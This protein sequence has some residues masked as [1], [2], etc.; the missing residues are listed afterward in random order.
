MTVR[1][2]RSNTNT[3]FNQRSLNNYKNMGWQ[4]WQYLLLIPTTLFHLICRLKESK[5]P[6]GRAIDLG[7]YKVHLWVKGTKNAGEPTIVLDHSLGGIEGYLLIDRLSVLGQVCIYDRP[8]YGWSDASPKPRCSA[9]IVRELDL[10]LTKAEIEPP[11][12]L[13]GDSFGS[14]NVRLYAHQFPKKVKGIVL[15]DGLHEA[16][17][18]N[19]P[20][21]IVAVKYLFI[22]GFIMSIFGSLSGIIRILGTFGLFEI[23]K[24]ELKQFNI[25]PRRRIKRSFYHYSHWLTMTRELINLNRSS[26]QVKVAQKLNAP[27][28]SIKS[29]NFFKP[30]LFTIILPLKTINR[31]RDKMHLELSSLSDDFT[32]IKAERS[33]HFVWTDE[34]EIIIKAVKQ[35]WVR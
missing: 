19:L 35:L 7:G 29:Q 8:G 18:L 25:L 12:I 28:I 30:S 2:A 14:Y 27:I 21:T 23:I 4:Y 3:G 20:K 33:S 24:P 5:I 9:E 1:A 11:Y 17:M 32:K 31:L 16:G 10:M 26:R 34:P 22:S 6:P 13:V 15:T